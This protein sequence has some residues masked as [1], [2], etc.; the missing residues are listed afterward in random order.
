[1]H[2][3]FE[4][5]LKMSK[6]ESRHCRRWRCRHDL[7]CLCNCKACAK[8]RPEEEMAAWKKSRD[9]MKDMKPGLDAVFGKGL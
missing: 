1:M 3:R 6:A 8:L 2:I 5:V 4:V 9:S 7:V